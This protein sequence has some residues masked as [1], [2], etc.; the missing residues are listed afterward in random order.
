M[1]KN[2]DT[3]ADDL[4]DVLAP[5]QSE[6]PTPEAPEEVAPVAPAAEPELTPA[7]ESP[8]L[9]TP[10]D[11]PVDAAE[12]PHSIA[13]EGAAQPLNTPDLRP[14]MA[15]EEAP[16]SAVYRKFRTGVDLSDDEL[17]LLLR[18]D[19]KKTYTQYMHSREPK[20]RFFIPL[21]GGMKIE[22]EKGTGRKLYP[23]KY[24]SISEVV[25]NI[26][27]G[28]YVDVPQSVADLLSE[29]LNIPQEVSVAP[30]LGAI[31]AIN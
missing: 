8:A 6:S 23:L 22:I 4:D 20:V 9:E 17:K 24:V 13:S 25:Y 1:S 19:D 5:A 21:E 2:K 29:N 30:M 15:T 3:N 11:V 27:M 31:S 10:L 7:P 18:L 12:L 28:I 14:A 16:E 26:P